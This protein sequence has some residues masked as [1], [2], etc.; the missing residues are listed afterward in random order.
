MYKVYKQ[1]LIY[2][3]INEVKLQ[4]SSQTP[5]PWQQD[6]YTVLKWYQTNLHHTTVKNS[7]RPHLH[8]GKSLGVSCKILYWIITNSKY[9]HMTTSS[10]HPLHSSPQHLFHNLEDD[11]G[12]ETERHDLPLST[13]L[14][15]F[16]LKNKYGLLRVLS[17]S[18]VTS[19][20][21]CYSANYKV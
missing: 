7:G 3:K 5:W 9:I 21:K 19:K 4:L 1:L 15:S 20:R 14:I 17:Q 16:V 13:Q 10:T 18:Y 6:W 12:W 2:K 8:H 11:V